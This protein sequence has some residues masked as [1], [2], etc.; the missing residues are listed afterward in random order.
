MHDN[1]NEFVCQTKHP[2][3][4]KVHKRYTLFRGKSK[5]GRHAEASD[6][7]SKKPSFFR[8]EN[9]A[10]TR[11]MPNQPAIKIKNRVFTEPQPPAESSRA[12]RQPHPF[13]PYSKNFFAHLRCSPRRIF[14]R[15]FSC[16]RW[17][18][19]TSISTSQRPSKWFFL[20]ASG[21]YLLLLLFARIAP[22]GFRRCSGENPAASGCGC[23]IC[24][25]C[26]ESCRRTDQ[27]LPRRSV[28]W[29]KQPLSGAADAVLLCVPRLCPVAA[30]NRPRLAG[31]GVPARRMHCEPAWRAASLW[32]RP[33]A[34]RRTCAKATAGAFSPPSATR[35]STRVTSCWRFAFRW[36]S[37]SARKNE[38]RAYSLRVDS[39]D[40]FLF[41]ALVAG[42]TA[43]RLACLPRLRS[44]RCCCFQIEHPCAVCRWAGRSSSSVRLSSDYSQPR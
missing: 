3:L 13:L 12:A 23:A 6:I 34:S 33:K 10:R 22:A 11:E 21:V 28:L 37:S 9:N 4:R 31:A 18:S 44:R 35:T 24:A 27:P 40:C 43:R 39:C 2:L 25:L 26:R 36:G 15:C 38:A 8:F 30:K 5:E 1:S 19:A 16:I 14:A 17:C 20:I 32:N 7:C 42:A 29:R 41:G